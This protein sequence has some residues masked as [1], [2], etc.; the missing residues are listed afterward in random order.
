[1]ESIGTLASGIAHDLNNILAPIMM[2]ID[3]L[4][5]DSDSPETK[6]ILE[7]IGVSAK[8]GADTS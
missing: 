5:S 8:R 6:Q 4:K 7:T 2:S 3:I 1:M